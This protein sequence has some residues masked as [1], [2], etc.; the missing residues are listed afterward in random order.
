MNSV[1]MPQLGES[2]SGGT[3][4]RRLKRAGDP[5]AVVEPPFGVATDTVN[6]EIPSLYA[7]VIS[8]LIVACSHL[9][10][11]SRTSSR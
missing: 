10:T 1:A 8:E 11:R 6:T 7:R 5:I 9:K 4:V 3:V 2:V